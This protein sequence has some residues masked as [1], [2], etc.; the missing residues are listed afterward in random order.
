M[1]TI[2]DDLLEMPPPWDK[3]K[4]FR[5]IEIMCHKATCGVKWNETLTTV[6]W[7]C[8]EDVR[9]RRDYQDR[10][11]RMPVENPKFQAPNSVE[12]STPS[13]APT[14]QPAPNSN[15]LY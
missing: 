1:L 5:I 4:G 15:N 11:L 10:M 2:L 6:C 13:T 7:I 9:K 3:P 14:N 8:G 12:P